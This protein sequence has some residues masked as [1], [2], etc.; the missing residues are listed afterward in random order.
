MQRY[1]CAV[2]VRSIAL[3]LLESLQADPFLH[4]LLIHSFTS[5]SQLPVE[6]LDREDTTVQLLLY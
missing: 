1:V 6:L 5:T 2:T 4:G 3:E